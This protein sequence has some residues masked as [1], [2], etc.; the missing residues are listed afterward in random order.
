MV[1]PLCM[2]RS[3]ALAATGKAMAPPPWLSRRISEF[4]IVA[5]AKPACLPAGCVA[6]EPSVPA[7]DETPMKSINVRRAA[8]KT[9]LA[10]HAPLLLPVAH[11]ALTARLIDRAGF[12]AYQ[13][14]GFALAAAM[15]A[16]P[17]LDLEHFG[18]KSA[19]ARNIIHASPLPVLVD[20]DDGYG[21]VKNVTR[22]V[23]EYEVMGASAIFMEDQVAPK[24]CGHMSGKR[25]VSRA[26]MVSKIKAAVAARA[27]PDFFILARTD[28]IEPNGVSD[29]IR[30]GQ[31]YLEA[32]ADGV[33]LEGPRN[34][35]ELEKIGRAF[36]GKPLATSILE[37]GGKTPWLP[38]KEMHEMGFTMLLYPTTLLFRLTRTLE[39]A[40]SHLAHGRP[41]PKSNSCSME[42]FEKIVDMPHW[43]ELEKKFLPP[44]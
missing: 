3:L 15:N 21:D 19:A 4:P 41:M 5:R 16:V 38:P 11:D 34:V 29:A 1:A 26:E 31:A 25:V 42:K 22:T 32:G 13:I 7:S 37:G 30:R 9:I 39:L 8:W 40:L 27:T 10:D 23:N 18:E 35:D 2:S 33:Y 36:K 28:A 43:A 6:A 14:G 17:D 44:R 20:A 12:K 24:R